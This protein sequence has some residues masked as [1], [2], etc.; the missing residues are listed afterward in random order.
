MSTN[1]FVEFANGGDNRLIHHYDDLLN[2]EQTNEYE[3]ITINRLKNKKEYEIYLPECN[4][5]LLS[6]KRKRSKITV[7][8]NCFGT[9][10]LELL[11]IKTNFKKN[12]FVIYHGVNIIAKLFTIRKMRAIRQHILILYDNKHHLPTTY[13]NKAPIYDEKNKSFNLNFATNGTDNIITQESIKNCVFES[14]NT[15][16]FLKFGKKDKQIFKLCYRN[17]ISLLQAIG[18][19]MCLF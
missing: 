2:V 9:Q 16:E 6:I 12:R 10:Q 19:S 11:Y 8:V 3:I 18:V 14:Q 17:P 5:L 15:R 13:Y 7:N 1:Q 4:N